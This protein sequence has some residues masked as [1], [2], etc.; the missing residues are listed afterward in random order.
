MVCRLLLRMSGSLG[1]QPQGFTV[2]R[3]KATTTPTVSL[4]SSSLVIRKGSY[5]RTCCARECHFPAAG[6]RNGVGGSFPPGF[7]SRGQSYLAGGVLQHAFL[8]SGGSMTDLGTLGGSLSS[9]TSR[10]KRFAKALLAVPKAEITSA[11]GRS[12]VET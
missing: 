5:L 1:P 2:R 12:S 8:Y 4:L 10:G 7:R 6:T 11:A 3:E 9:A